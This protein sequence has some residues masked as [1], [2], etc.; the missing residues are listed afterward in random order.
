MAANP[1]PNFQGQPCSAIEAV[2]PK[3][4]LIPQLILQHLNLRDVWN[5]RKTNKTMNVLL[6]GH[7]RP[8]NP[9]TTLSFVG[10]H[11]DEMRKA[12]VIVANVPCPNGP[13]AD[14]LMKYC[15][16]TNEHS[17]DKG[18]E[19]NVCEDCINHNNQY[20][21]PEETNSMQSRWLS[22]CK[23]CQDDEERAFPE[24]RN[25]C[26][27][28]DEI[29]RGWKCDACC[30]KVMSDIDGRAARRNLRLGCFYRRRNG[31]TYFDFS[32]L[33]T[34]QGC[35][36]GRSCGPGPQANQRAVQWCLGCKGMIVRPSNQPNA[37]NKGKVVTRRSDRV[38]KRKL[39]VE[40]G[41]RK[42]QR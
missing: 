4:E 33:R 11:C 25:T 32:R 16:N 5:L 13:R 40:E 15:E 3:T 28:R 12:Q 19:F 26:L 31:T 30:R 18:G 21:D 23:T 10:A 34:G 8:L 27:C 2:W 14:V 7:S 42:K 35:P 24:G 36:C 6:Q 9:N 38:K 22:A 37:N 29:R 1:P 20:R 41:Q 39:E 17:K